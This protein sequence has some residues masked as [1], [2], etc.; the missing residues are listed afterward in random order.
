[1]I[2]LKEGDSNTAFFHRVV[3]FKAKR[4]IVFGM[5]IGNSWFIEPKVLK[6]RMFKFF[7][8][9][10]SYPSRRWI[11]DLELNFKR[12]RDVY[13]MNLEKPFSL[14]EINE[15]VWSCDENKALGLDGFNFYFFRKCWEVVKDDLF[16]MI[17]K[18]FNTRKL[19]KSI[20]SSFIALIPKN[21]NPQ[22]I[23]ELRPINL[24]SPLYKI[25]A[26]F[27]SRKLRAVIGDVVSDTQCDFIRG[28]QIFYGI[29]VAN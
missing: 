15:A 16:V 29:L 2:W 8:N 21:D 13:V 1:M 7:K 24:V 23:S 27:L 28:R 18:F 22:D 26:K 4:K 25:V 12:L 17:A 20:N 9:H 5:K 19:E 6:E 14:E 11:M 10:F 3:K